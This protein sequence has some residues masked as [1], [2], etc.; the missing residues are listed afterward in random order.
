MGEHMLPASLALADQFLICELAKP[1][2][3][4]VEVNAV[5]VEAV[6]APILVAL[7]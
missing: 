7:V 5:L 6:H 3:Q 4:F 1:L 2:P